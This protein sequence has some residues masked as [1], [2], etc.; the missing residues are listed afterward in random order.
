[1]H[2]VQYNYHYDYTITSGG[3][4]TTTEETTNERDLG[5]QIDRDLKFDQQMEMVANKANK[6]LGLIRSFTYLDGPTM[7][8][9]YTRLVRPILEYG[10]VVWAPTHKRD[11]HT[12]SD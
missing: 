1:M 6:I 11:Q 4:D 7:K 12:Y 5:V 2:L 10:N 3:K 8:N 9:L